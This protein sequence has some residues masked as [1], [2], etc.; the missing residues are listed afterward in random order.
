M[1]HKD[2]ISAL[3][4]TADVLTLSGDPYSANVAYGHLWF[5]GRD[6]V[7]TP[8]PERRPIR[9]NL[10]PMDE[11]K[12]REAIEE[13]NRRRQIYYIAPRIM[14]M[15]ESRKLFDILPNLRVIEAPDKWTAILWMRSSEFSNG[16][17]DVLLCTTIVE[18]G[19]IFRIATRLSSK[20]CNVR[21]SVVV[22]VAWSRRS[23][24]SS[25]ACLDVY[26]LD[27]ESLNEKAKERLLALEE[28][29]GLGEGFKL[30]KETCPFEAPYSLRRETIRRSRFGWCRF[31]PGV[32]L[33]AVTAR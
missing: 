32:A 7:Q 22:S 20:K 9:T 1:R 16:E 2:Q 25:S 12:I 33:F 28:S 19:L 4:A 3:K 15:G 23:C 5:S 26:G 13:I 21:L 31:V 30:A 14:M 6:L 18:S 17:A 8:P 29:C 27:P 24:R 10:L 11:D